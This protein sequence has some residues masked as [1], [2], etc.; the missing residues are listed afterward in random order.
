MYTERDRTV[1]MVAAMIQ[2]EANLSVDDTLEERCRKAMKIGQ[3]HWMI[4]DEDERFRASVGAVILAS[5]DEE[6][7]RISSEL[8]GLR[9]LSAAI[10]GVPVDFDQLPTQENPVGLMKIWRELKG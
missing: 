7:E 2:A 1:V 3:N 9:M 10:S 4:T 6:R 5:N 8:A